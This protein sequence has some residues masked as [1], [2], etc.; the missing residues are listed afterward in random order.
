MDG[1]TSNNTANEPTVSLTYGMSETLRSGGLLNQI[2]K[3]SHK[4]KVCLI[5]YLYRTEN[6]DADVFDQL[7]DTAIPYTAEELNA[8]ID[9]SE[10]EIEHGEG[11]TFEEMF[12]G[13]KQQLLWLK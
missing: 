3:L 7:E 1:I 2:S 8:R 13:F 4:D 6:F 5:R 12:S 10:A 9:E 11:K